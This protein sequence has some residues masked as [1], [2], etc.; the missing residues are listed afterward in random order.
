MRRQTVLISAWLTLP[1]VIIAAL[2]V[3]IFVSM[4]KDRLMDGAPPVG[5]G[6]GDTGNANALGQWLAG[7]DPDAVARALRARREGL[8][9]DPASWPGGMRLTASRDLVGADARAPI[10]VTLEP[11]VGAISSSPLLPQGAGTLSALLR[12]PEA[13]GRVVYLSPG[14]VSLVSG[15]PV[16]P[17]GRALAPI[18]I[19]ARVPDRELQV[20]DPIPVRLDAPSIYAD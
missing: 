20:S 4:D 7:R 16:A 8:A 5:A 13:L 10:V 2:M 12:H 9:I 14:P 3:W 6:A 17:D 11:G 15:S 1:I 18:P 19:G